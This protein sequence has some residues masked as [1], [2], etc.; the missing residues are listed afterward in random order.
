MRTGG[1][2]RP[3]YILPFDRRGSFQM[4]IVGWKSAPTAEIAAARQ[5]ICDGFKA[6]IEDGAPEPSG[7]GNQQERA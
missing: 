1:F 6:A 3:L 4:K 2:E 5:V 7:F